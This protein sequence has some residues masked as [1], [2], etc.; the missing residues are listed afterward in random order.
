M[1]VL[2]FSAHA[3]DE[4]IGIAGTLC[5]LADA[6]A[7]IRLVIFSEGAEGYTTLDEEQTIVATRDRETR[8]VC[9]ILGIREYINLHGLDWNLK[10]DNAAYHAVMTQIRE[11]QPE[12]IFS[13]SYADYSDHKVTHDVVTE[14]WFHAGI[15]C[16]MQTGPVWPAPPLYEFEVLQPL[17]NPTHIV[18]ITDT[19]TAKVAAMA[20]YGSQLE[21][22]GGIFQ[23]ME[24]RALERGYL[25]GARYGE[26]LQRSSYRPA[27]I[28]AVRGLIC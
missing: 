18:D 6:G 12:L 7:H 14:G 22:V 20:C 10:V 23:L 8:Q 28:R 9:E 17:A 13:H 1:N 3:D 25:I 26:A 11:F 15:P 4:V 5:K 19:Y 27:A 16:A 21:L 24:G 2:V